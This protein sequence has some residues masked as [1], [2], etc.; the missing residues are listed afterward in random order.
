MWR[1]RKPSLLDDITKLWRCGI[2]NSCNQPTRHKSSCKPIYTKEINFLFLLIPYT[3]TIGSLGA[4]GKPRISL[5]RIIS[6]K[7]ATHGTWPWQVSIKYGKKLLCGGVLISPKHVLSAAHCF[8]D[9]PRRFM[10]LLTVV[11]GNIIS[12]YFKVKNFRAF[13]FFAPFRESWFPR[14]LSKFSKFYFFLLKCFYI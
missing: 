4:C 10:K 9:V 14:N 3:L 5:S 2:R 8:A 6:G 11:S 1:Y 13:A 12:Y 7:N